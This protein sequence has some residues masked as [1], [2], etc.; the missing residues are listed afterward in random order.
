MAT[1]GYRGGYAPFNEA[2]RILIERG[3]FKLPGGDPA[4]V[5]RRDKRLEMDVDSFPFGTFKAVSFERV[6]K[7]DNFRLYYE[8]TEG[9]YSE[10]IELTDMPAEEMNGSFVWLDIKPKLR[11]EALSRRLNR[12]I[13]TWEFPIT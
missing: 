5:I 11:S 6:G 2:V 10:T 12:R 7:T 3:V 4:K 13:L 8:S 9:C 1:K